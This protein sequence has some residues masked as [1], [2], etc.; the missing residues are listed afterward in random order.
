MTILQDLQEQIQSQQDAYEELETK[1][2]SAWNAQYALEDA[3]CKARGHG[4]GLWFAYSD[5]YRHE[6]STLITAEI[7]CVMLNGMRYE[8]IHTFDPAQIQ[9]V[10][11]AEDEQMTE[12]LED[13]QEIEISPA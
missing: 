7:N 9:G 5:G 13:Q 11:E 8:Y 6:N 3:F 1:A 4:D 12:D 10:M 2:K